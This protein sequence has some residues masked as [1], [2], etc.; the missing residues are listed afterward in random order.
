MT[1]AAA[2]TVL[3]VFIRFVSQATRM[4]APVLGAAQEA[5]D[6]GDVVYSTDSTIRA[7]KCAPVA[8]QVR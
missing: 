5:L 3:E 6:S 8:E 4:G 2:E 7:P 1:E